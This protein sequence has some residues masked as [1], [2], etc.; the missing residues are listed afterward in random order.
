VIV[1]DFADEAVAD[2]SRSAFTIRDP[3]TVSAPNG[4]ASYDQGDTL[5]VTWTSADVSLVNVY[6]TTD[7]GTWVT[8][9]ASVP[10]GSSSCQW[11]VP[12]ISSTTCRI[13]ITNAEDDSDFDLSDSNFTISSVYQAAPGEW[14]Q[15]GTM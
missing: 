13:K 9:I 4:G 10:S 2:T 6:Y 7:G 14:L 11:V 5:T 3:L 12:S 15:S 1:R 8:I